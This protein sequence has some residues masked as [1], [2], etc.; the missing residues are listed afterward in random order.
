VISGE[1]ISPSA[2]RAAPRGPSAVAATRHYGT[3]VGYTV[4]EAA[5]V[6]F[7]IVQSRAG[8]KTTGGRCVKPTKANR[9]AHTCARLVAL[10]GGFTRASSAGANSFGFSGRLAGR[11]LATGKYRLVATPSVG[12]KAG[13]AA[14]AAFQIIK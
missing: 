3:K 13:R 6:S 8:R 11:K 7:T 10:A 4:N 12:A 5:N 1:T 9:T 2:F 14:S